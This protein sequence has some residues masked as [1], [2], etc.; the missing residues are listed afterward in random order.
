M[1]VPMPMPERAATRSGPEP[2]LRELV[3][4]LL[5]SGEDWFRTELQ[6]MRIDARQFMRRVSTCIAVTVC[7]FALL[8]AAFVVFFNALI[9][10]LADYLESA[11]L[12]GLFVGTGMILAGALLLAAALRA[13][14][15]PWVAVSTPLRTLAGENEKKGADERN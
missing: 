2:G 8:V 14:T 12:A 4:R 7:A 13:F 11:M 10:P 5:H 9:V 15:R 6:L 1:A 3:S